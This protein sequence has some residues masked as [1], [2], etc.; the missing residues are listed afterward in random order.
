MVHHALHADADLLPRQ[1]LRWGQIVGLGAGEHIARAAALSRL[2]STYEDEPFWLGFGHLLANSPMADPRQIGPVVD[3]LFAQKFDALGQVWDNGI[4]RQMGPPQPGLCLKGRNFQS[5]LRQ[6]NVWHR[7]LAR[8]SDKSCLSWGP[9][10]VRAFDRV[11][12]E[13]GKQRRFVV[14]ELLNSAELAA[15]GRFMR[16]CV[17]SYA[18]S[19][20]RGRCAVFSLRQDVG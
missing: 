10:G 15:E 13:P 8:V 2:G 16:H 6:V 19:C 3:Y 9:S 7:R 18:M 11:E 17:Y 5:L 1:A 20:A 4:F 14:V 12:G